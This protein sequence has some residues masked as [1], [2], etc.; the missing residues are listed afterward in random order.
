MRGRGFGEGGLPAPVPNPR[1]AM[2]GAAF[3]AIRW[4]RNGQNRRIKPAKSDWINSRSAQI[5]A[6]RLNKNPFPATTIFTTPA[7]P[8]GRSAQ[9]YCRCG[10]GRPRPAIG[11]ARLSLPRTLAR[12][13]SSALL[14]VRDRPISCPEFVS[15]AERAH[16]GLGY[17]TPQEFSPLS[18][19]QRSDPGHCHGM[20]G[21]KGPDS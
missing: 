17:L 9:A 2:S 18:S 6:P 8:L 11:D 13:S 5:D 1:K 16:S 4:S 7:G 19:H 21:S 12:P 14:A 20:I 10:T 3:G 15:N